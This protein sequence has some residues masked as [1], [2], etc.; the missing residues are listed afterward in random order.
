VEPQ[1]EHEP[2][3][4]FLRLDEGEAVLVYERR[5]EV[6]D[7][8]H[9]W[10]PPALRGHDVAARLTE[11]AFIYARRE[12]LKIL[13]TCSFTRRYLARHPELR[14]LAVTR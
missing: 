7:V 13:P 1:V 3:K 14:E 9:T 11:A 10:A 12:G 6:L 8:R 4:F 5:G 2:G